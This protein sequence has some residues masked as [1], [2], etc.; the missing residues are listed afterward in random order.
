MSDWNADLPGDP[1]DSGFTHWRPAAQCALPP[2]ARRR[3]EAKIESVRQA[4]L[5]AQAEAGQSVVG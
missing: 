5:R 3:V 2:E 1:L 4:R